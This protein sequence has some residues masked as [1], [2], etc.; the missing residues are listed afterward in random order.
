M[1]AKIALR[2]FVANA[3]SKCL[4][5]ATGLPR[6]SLESHASNLDMN[7]PDAFVP[8]CGF[9]VTGFFSNPDILQAP[10]SE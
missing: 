10:V 5:I 2:S 8:D 7:I 1:A 9:W 4:A 3:L 6:N